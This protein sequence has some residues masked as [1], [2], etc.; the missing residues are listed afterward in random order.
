MN[1]NMAVSALGMMFVFG[2]ITYGIA[3]KPTP[4]T[5][6]FA[7]VTMGMYIWQTTYVGANADYWELRYRNRL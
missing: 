6:W 4:L 1:K 2:F 5:A 7:L 3:V